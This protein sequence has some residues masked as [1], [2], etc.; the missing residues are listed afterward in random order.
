M[1]PLRYPRSLT[2]PISTVVSPPPAASSRRTSNTPSAPLRNARRE[3]RS[4][5][6]LLLSS[7]FSVTLLLRMHERLVDHLTRKFL[8]VRH[9]TQVATLNHPHEEKI[10]RR[11]HPE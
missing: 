9:R 10:V 3:G 5:I 6:V 7:C 4:I 11:I 8:H 2:C 1:S